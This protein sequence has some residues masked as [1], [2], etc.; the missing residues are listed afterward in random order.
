M[1]RIAAVLA[2]ASAAIASAGQIQVGGV[3]GLTNAYITSGCSGSSCIAGSAGGFIEQNY[4]EVLFSGASNG[5]NT[6]VPYSTYSTTTANTGTISD[7]SQTFSMIN[8]GVKS[9]GL[10]SRNVWVGA[11]SNP[12]DTITVPI[13]VYGVSNVWTMIN[14]VLANVGARDLTVEFDF[15]STSN[16][17]SVTAIKVKPFD[18]GASGVTTGDSVQNAVQCPTSA[19][20]SGLANGAPDTPVSSPSA[21]FPGVTMVSDQLLGTNFIYTAATGSYAG[22]TGN[23]GLDDQDFVFTGSTLALA[24]GSYLVDVKVIEADSVGSTEVAL[25]AI[26]LDTAAPEPSTVLMFLTGLGAIGFARFRRA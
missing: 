4:D 11:S 19:A 3:N 5:S 18:T 8:D 25:S 24:L 9:G 15:G 10:G 23:V 1:L 2:I 16:A 14:T 17:S 6:P 20:C 22:T 7:G 21:N 12:N 13:G 26:T